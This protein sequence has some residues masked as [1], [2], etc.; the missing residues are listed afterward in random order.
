VAGEE[1]EVADELVLT[2]EGGAAGAEP[3]VVAAVLLVGAEVGED[4]EVLEVAAVAHVHLGAVAALVVVLGADHGLER[5]ELGVL[6]VPAAALLRARVVRLHRRQSSLL[7]VGHQGGAA[8]VLVAVRAHVH[9]QVGVALEPLAA[10]LAVVGVLGQQLT[11]IQLDDRRSCGGRRLLLVI[12][13]RIVADA[14]S[15]SHQLVASAGRHCGC[16]SRACS[17]HRRAAAAGGR[18][19]CGSRA[20]AGRRTSSRRRR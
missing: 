20:A 13:L 15:Q 4:G 7:L 3:T 9:P 10:H 6:P 17:D 2:G 18:L 14:A 12:S 11:G 16:C 5:L 8:L 19:V 1:G